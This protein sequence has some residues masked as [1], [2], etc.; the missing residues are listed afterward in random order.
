M[1]LLPYR[2]VKIFLIFSQGPLSPYFLAILFWRNFLKSYWSRGACARLSKKLHP[3]TAEVV[4]RKT[5]ASVE[6]RSLPDTR[7]HRW[8]EIR[9]DTGLRGKATRKGGRLSSG[10]CHSKSRLASYRMQRR[11]SMDPAASQRAAERETQM[12]GKELLP[13]QAMGSCAVFG[14]MLATLTQSS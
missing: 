6:N 5:G 4:S 1:V 9:P 3:T 8:Q 11:Y 2:E 13:N 10:R 12:A 14:T 7:I